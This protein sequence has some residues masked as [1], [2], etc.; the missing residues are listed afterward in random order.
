[1]SAYIVK[2]HGRVSGSVTVS[3]YWTEAGRPDPVM[4]KHDVVDVSAKMQKHLAKSSSSGAELLALGNVLR[5]LPA[6]S[7]VTA[8]LQQGAFLALLR[9]NSNRGLTP[10]LGHLVG[11]LNFDR[12]ERGIALSIR[13]KG[14]EAIEL[15]VPS[16]FYK[17]WTGYRKSVMDAANQGRTV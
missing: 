14:R 17:D 6:G 4:L 10:A 11:R 2:L 1:M 3:V 13:E 8:E 5:H 9:L 12:A 15:W 7:S 16:Q